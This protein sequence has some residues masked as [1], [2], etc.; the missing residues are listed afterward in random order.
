[1]TRNCIHARLYFSYPLWSYTFSYDSHTH[2]Y[3][4]VFQAQCL[5]S[6]SY[7]AQQGSHCLV[8][9]L[10]CIWLWWVR[11]CTAC[12]GARCSKRAEVPSAF[13]QCQQLNSW[14]HVC[15]AATFLP[16][17]QPLS[18]LILLVLYHIH[19]LLRL[20][21]QH[22]WGLWF[23]KYIK[24]DEGDMQSKVLGLWDPYKKVVTGERL[25][26]RKSKGKSVKKH[27]ISFIQFLS[28]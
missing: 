14:P 20:R 25:L 13:E 24:H 2:T 16:V 18:S 6:F 15:I 1:M 19:R 28:S 8:A 7:R 3:L 12:C 4:D 27:F 26:D 5:H 11:D 17:S 9:L 23:C 21:Q 22:V 10:A